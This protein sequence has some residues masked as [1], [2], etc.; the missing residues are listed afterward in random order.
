MRLGKWRL[1]LAA[2][3]TLLTV[4]A[5]A[6]A[7]AAANAAEPLPTLR[8][9][10]AERFRVGVAVST[11]A[12]TQ[13][14]WGVLA[15]VARQFSSVTPE[16]AMK[17]SAIHP[18]PGEYRFTAADRLVEL[19]ETHGQF[20]VGHTL[21]WHK[22]TPNWVF[23]G[24]GGGPA[25]RRLLLDRMREHI[26]RV[27]GRYRGKVD[28]WD[29]VNEAVN[30][31]GSLRDSPW[32]R[33]IGD[34]YVEQAFRFAAEADPGAELY[35]NDYR[36]YVPAKRA[37][38]IR[39]VRRLQAAGLRIDGAGI[40]GHWRL[41]RPSRAQAER[42]IDE[43]AAAAGKVMI[44]ELDIGLLPRPTV[45]A[46]GAPA[47]RTAPTVELDPYRTGLTPSGQRRLADRYAALFRLFA[48]RSEV[49]D[50]VT[51]WGVDDGRSWLNN[52]P[53]RGRTAHPLLFDRQLQPKPAYNAVVE[54]AR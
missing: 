36:M 38:V 7:S 5:N 43:L 15:H 47:E 46:G 50:R 11:Q 44:T 2:G 51:F 19:A 17:W 20:V 6:G 21:V 33:I 26:D 53:V 18:Q 1:P 39:L 45:E 34:D 25:S 42:T 37:G 22:Q 24:P 4:A 41:D 35:Y 30:E 40:Q 28:A 12:L 29:V 9:A 14:E 3:A 49:I 13:P 31:D 23:R 8:E 32:R 10:Y 52:H 54:A 16:N 27:V 48:R